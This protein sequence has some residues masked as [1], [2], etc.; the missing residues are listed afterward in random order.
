MKYLHGKLKRKN[1][2]GIIMI[3]LLSIGK[4]YMENLHGEFKWK[5]QIKVV[6]NLEDLYGKS[7]RIIQVEKQ[8]TKSNG[9]IKRE[10]VGNLEDYMD[11]LSGE[12]KWKI[13]ME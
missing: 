8:Y 3:K 5:I 1:H 2:G 10:V 11:N 6:S 4:I 9:R 12:F 7:T 13:Q